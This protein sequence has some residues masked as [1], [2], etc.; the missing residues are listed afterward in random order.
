MPYKP[1]TAVIKYAV[2]LYSI[3]L[4]VITPTYTITT[5]FP[6][7]VSI[8]KPKPWRRII[9]ITE[10]ARHRTHHLFSQFTCFFHPSFLSRKAVTN[11]LLLFSEKLIC[12]TY[13][14]VTYCTTK[15]I[16]VLGKNGFSKLGRIWF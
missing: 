9:Q 6:K 2:K 11:F 14:Y 1:I 16:F 4:K 5:A 12:I 8:R 13:E 15:F 3:G 7:A 10:K